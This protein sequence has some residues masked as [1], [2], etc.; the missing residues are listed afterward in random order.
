MVFRPYPVLTLLT[1]AGLGVLIALGAW[2]LDRRAWKAGLVA[3]YEAQ[4]A[5]EPVDMETALCLGQAAPGLPARAE[6]APYA[7]HGVRLYSLNRQGAP[8]WRLFVPLQAP[9]CAG[10][11]FILAEA[12]FDP[13]PVS[14]ASPEGPPARLRYERPPRAGLFTPSHRGGGEFHAFDR[15]A[16]AAALSLEPDALIAD[17]LLAADDGRPPAHLTQTP[18]AQHLGYAVTWFGMALALIGVYLVFHIKTGRL[19]RTARKP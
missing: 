17:W 11:G 3:Q 4:L 7:G 15:D 2:Q 1:L 5:G 6:P 16:M 19:R 9:V 8:G 14:P 10:G 18:P 12:G 13:L